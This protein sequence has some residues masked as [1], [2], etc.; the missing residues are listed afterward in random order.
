M[1]ALRERNITHA[2]LEVGSID[3]DGAIKPC[4]DGI[5]IRYAL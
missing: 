4:L 3:H 2:F 5:V 1:P